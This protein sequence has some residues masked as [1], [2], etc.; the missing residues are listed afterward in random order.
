MEAPITPGNELQQTTHDE[1][2]PS[3]REYDFCDYANQLD[4][5]PEAECFEQE[6]AMFA[7]IPGI[8]GRAAELGEQLTSTAFGKQFGT[9]NT[10]A[11]PTPPS[12]PE[13][14]PSVVDESHDDT[15][16][17]GFL[18]NDKS[19]GTCT[20]PFAGTNVTPKRWKHTAARIWDCCLPALGLFHVLLALTPSLAVPHTRSIILSAVLTA[21]VFISLFPST[22]DSY[23]SPPYLNCTALATNIGITASALQTYLID[24]GCS[25]SIIEDTQYLLNIRLCIPVHVKGICGVKTLVMSADLH[26]PARTAT[27]INHTVVIKDVLYDP[28]RHFNLLSTDQLNESRYDVMLTADKSL[29]SLHFRDADGASRHIPITRVGK[30]YNVPVFDFNVPDHHALAGNC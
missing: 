28:D 8:Q 21:M 3:G 22:A 5:D 26:L 4:P 13:V 14:F 29:R 16:E 18:S 19:T 30:L 12:L 23:L 10:S 9:D 24:S 17:S 1:Y 20:N 27:H 7:F 2:T 15:F 25:T 6:E 11:E